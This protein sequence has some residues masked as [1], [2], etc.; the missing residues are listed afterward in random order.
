MAVTV[1]A[2]LLFS[3]CLS[4]RITGILMTLSDA[5][6]THRTYHLNKHFCIP[7]S[8]RESLLSLC[9]H[10]MTT[11]VKRSSLTMILNGWAWP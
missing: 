11:L 9:C 8:V 1:T 5:D 6:F 2:K 4:L 3:S 10:K 7:Y